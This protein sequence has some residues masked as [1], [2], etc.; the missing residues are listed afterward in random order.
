M[1]ELQTLMFVVLV[2]TSQGVVYLVRERHH[3][4]DSRPS[5]WLL[6][7]STLEIA[8]VCLLASRGI[9]MA[10]LAPALLLGTAVAVAVY[11]CAVD[12]LKVRMFKLL[13]FT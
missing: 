8:V 1:P 11:L 10:P 7:S 12:I 13:S 3:F 4:W 6:A 5:S 2:F 9:L